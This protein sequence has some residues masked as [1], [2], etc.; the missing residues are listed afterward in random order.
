M[1]SRVLQI[2]FSLILGIGAASYSYSVYAIFVRRWNYLTWDPAAHGWDGM[3]LALNIKELRPLDLL[4]ETNHLVLWP[5]LH[6]YLEVPYFLIL[7]FEYRSAV[8]C[9]LTFLALLLPALTLVHQQLDDSWGGW[10]VL[11]A[12]ALTSPALLGYSSMPMHEIFGATLT[13]FSGSL[14]LQRS[15]WF[16]LSLALLFFLKY[17]YFFYLLPPV[18]LV[19]VSKDNLTRVY[20]WVRTMKSL[21]VLL[22]LFLAF[23]IFI[24]ITGGTKIGPVSIRGVGNPAY[25]VFLVSLAILV[26]KKQHVLLWQ[27]IKGTGWEL[28]VFP[29]LIWLLIPVPNRIKTILSFTIS[30]S[31]GGPA[32]TELEYYLYYLRK[33]PLYFPGDWMAWLCLVTGFVVT[34][35]YWRKKEILFVGS[36]FWLPFFMMMLNQNK[37]ERYLFTFVPALW[38]LF[39]YAINRIPAKIAQFAAALAVCFALAFSLNLNSV[40]QT[41]RLQFAQSGVRGPLHYIAKGIGN[42]KQV[43]VLGVT[44]ELNPGSIQ[45]HSA[46]HSGFTVDRHFEWEIESRHSSE[47]HVVCINCEI[48]GDLLKS[49]SFPDGLVIRHYFLDS[50]DAAS[51]NPDLVETAMS[52][53][54]SG[55]SFE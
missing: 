33:L 35:L 46:A 54:D 29:V 45:Y 20:D 4:A 40:R 13:A 32:P 7:G 43:R 15:K 26:W 12:L 3:R 24:L 50:P 37:Q 6:S 36:M 51:Y 17:N 11:M 42:A 49:R 16:P 41:I 18:L 48:H 10:L 9:S 34:V 21:V 27:K 22:V 28:F 52:R 31:F 47:L 55:A 19:Y 14:F 44:N 8:L 30:R 5:P 25:V 23:G 2:I 39:A 53:M 38:I 1:K